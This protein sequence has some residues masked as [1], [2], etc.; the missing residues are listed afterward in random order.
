MEGGVKTPTPTRSVAPKAKKK[1]K[2]RTV[3]LGLGKLAGP[4]GRGREVRPA[5]VL[6]AEVFLVDGGLAKLEGGAVAEFCLW[7]DGRGERGEGV[8]RA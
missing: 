1:H 5:Q 3:Q 8:R 6:L 2:T 4:A 7:M